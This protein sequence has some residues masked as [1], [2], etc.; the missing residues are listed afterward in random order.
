[1]AQAALGE[2]EPR[3][4]RRRGT[5]GRSTHG[6]AGPRSPRPAAH[7]ERHMHQLHALIAVALVAILATSSD[8]AAQPQ[9]QPR[10]GAVVIDVTNPQRSRYPIAVPPA[11]AG[12]SAAGRVV[13]QVM[14]FD[15]GVA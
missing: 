10:S 5:P 12:D 13:Q 9:G 15:L 11:T 14:A 1:P 4:L 6:D 8:L 7:G 3:S 2:C